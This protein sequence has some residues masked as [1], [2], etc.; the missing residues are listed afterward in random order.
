[1]TLDQTKIDP[2]GN[3]YEQF[4]DPGASP[5]DS[6]IRWPQDNLEIPEIQET[7]IDQMESCFDV[8]KK[9]GLV[10]GHSYRGDHPYYFVILTET[11]FIRHAKMVFTN[12]VGR[13]HGTVYAHLY[14]DARGVLVNEDSE[15]LDRYINQH[16]Y[17]GKLHDP[18][19]SM[20]P[21][22]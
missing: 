6:R 10:D 21:V 5:L 17:R 4:P 13:Q 20:K 2:R 9:L 14:W 18:I 11:A 15:V 22:A 8:A 7:D 1:M 3:M 19:H 12:G 16:H